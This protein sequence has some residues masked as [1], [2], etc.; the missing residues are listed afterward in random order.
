MTLTKKLHFDNDVLE[1]LRS[2]E[3]SADGLLGK[4][5]CG[6]LD[7]KMYEKVNKALEAMGGKWS[8]KDGGH[9]F[10]ADPRPSVDGLLENGVLEIE[11]DG[12][13]E[14]PKAVVDRM[15]ELVPITERNFILEPSAGMG[16]IAKNL[17]GE[18]GM[19]TCV[20]KNED[21]AE[22]LDQYGFPTYCADFLEWEPGLTFDR[23]YM[24][25][26]FENMQDVDHVKRA[27]ELLETG[28]KMV[29][30]M[31]SSPFFRQDKKAVDFVDWLSKKGGYS[32][33]LP[34]GSF[35]ESGTGVNTVL[36]VISK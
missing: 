1:V 31:S 22:Y 21:R 35:K 4:L 36:V 9:T 14:T 6:Q 24:N 8:R 17:P 23:I 7:R 26:P 15:L 27:Y 10:K 13:F 19:I 30:V 20:E 3:F 32:E 25:P 12:F 5:T 16:A 33:P 28:G 18:R 29:S 2:M 34:A 11:R